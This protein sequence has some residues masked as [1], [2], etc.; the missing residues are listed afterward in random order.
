[1]P[2]PDTVTGAAPPKSA[3]VGSPLIC[4]GVDPLGAIAVPP[5]EAWARA[6]GPDSNS[7]VLRDRIIV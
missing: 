3:A 5:V 4:A 2:C 6:K 1:M 7:S